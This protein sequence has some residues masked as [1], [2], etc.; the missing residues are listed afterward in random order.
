VTGQSV[1]GEAASR[2]LDYV[3]SHHDAHARDPDI[4]GG[5]KGSHPLWGSYA[6]FSYPNWAAKFFIDALLLQEEAGV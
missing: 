2:S 6:G 1:F 4:R 3:T 5:V